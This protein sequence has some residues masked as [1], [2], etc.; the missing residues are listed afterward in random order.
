MKIAHPTEEEKGRYFPLPLWFA[1]GGRRK[2]PRGKRRER[3][4]E[5]AK[6]EG[7]RQSGLGLSDCGKER[8]G[9]REILLPVAPVSKPFRSILH[10]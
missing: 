10:S 2:S 4:G 7:G 5:R 8:Q 9:E 1:G 6:R 3:R